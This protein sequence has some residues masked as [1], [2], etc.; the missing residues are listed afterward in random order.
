[1]NGSDDQNDKQAVVPLWSR[2]ATVQWIAKCG[3]Q[4]PKRWG[5]PKK[6]DVRVTSDN[7]PL[8]EFLCGELYENFWKAWADMVK[9]NNELEEAEKLP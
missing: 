9:A 2:R 1:M 4:R 3:T 8:Y 5:T 7:K 6:L